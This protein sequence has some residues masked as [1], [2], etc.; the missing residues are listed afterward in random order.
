[1]GELVREMLGGGH[2]IAW[3]RRNWMKTLPGLAALGAAAAVALGAGLG[4]SSTSSAAPASPQIA[5]WGF[6]LSGRDTAVAPGTDFYAYAD[7]DYVKKL[8]IPA[9]RSRYGSFDALQ[10][11]SET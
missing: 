3:K 5:P 1:M 10:A 6:D 11:L 9:D 8:V 2:D 4:L 7:G